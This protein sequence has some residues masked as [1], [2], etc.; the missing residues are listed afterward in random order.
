M[1]ANSGEFPG[2][3]YRL[4]FVFSGRTERI[5][6]FPF[7][8]LFRNMSQSDTVFFCGINSSVQYQEKDGNSLRVG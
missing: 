7:E 8:G 4:L 1:T 2:F 3:L 5:T 6:P